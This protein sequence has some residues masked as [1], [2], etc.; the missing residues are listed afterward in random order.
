MWEGLHGPGLGLVPAS[1]NWMSPVS[2][3]Q[4]RGWVP[5]APLLNRGRPFSLDFS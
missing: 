2:S 1:G 3:Q 4:R 5:L